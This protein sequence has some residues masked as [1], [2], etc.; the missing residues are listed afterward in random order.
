MATSVGS[1]VNS[2]KYAQVLEVFTKDS[3]VEQTT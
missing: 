1:A 3:A 2:I